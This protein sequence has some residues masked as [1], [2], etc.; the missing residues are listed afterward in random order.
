MLLDQ[1]KKKK[2]RLAGSRRASGG[3]AS[4]GPDAPT[5]ASGV[6]SS[7]T[8]DLKAEA[9]GGE[10]PGTVAAPALCLMRYGIA[11]GPI[12]GGV[13]QGKTPMFDI[14]GKTVNLASRMESTG[15]AGRIQVRAGGRVRSRLRVG[16]GIRVKVGFKDDVGVQSGQNG[17]G[18]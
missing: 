12:T 10:G 13:L 9:A 3:A 2:V 15:M 4:L 18:E 1:K 14:W 16:V 5:V 7:Y 17:Q 6:E 8:A 11:A